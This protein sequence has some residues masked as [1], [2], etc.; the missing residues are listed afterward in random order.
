MSAVDLLRRLTADAPHWTVD[1]DSH[2]AFATA[3]HANGAV[4]ELRREREGEPWVCDLGHPGKMQRRQHLRCAVAAAMVLEA[5]HLKLPESA[6][7]HRVAWLIVRA[8]NRASGVQTIAGLSEAAHN[9]CD[10]GTAA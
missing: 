9:D 8:E 4:I 5:M 1:G 2:A 10:R 3:E 6:A 7:L